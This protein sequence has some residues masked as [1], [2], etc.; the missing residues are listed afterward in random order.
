MRPKTKPKKTPPEPSPVIVVNGWRIYTHPLFINKL[1][2]LVGEVEQLRVA[3]P[4]GYLQKKKTKLLAAIYKM[5]FEVIPENP[6]D[7][8]FLQGNTLGG[9]YRHWRRAKFFEGRY[10]LFFRYSTTARVIVLA[11]VNDDDTL[12]TYGSKT[13]AYA[14]F[15]RMLDKDRPPDDL[16]AL[17]KEAK[18]A[19]A[20]GKKLVAIARGR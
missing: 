14:I 2:A 20:R 10:R 11:W 12:R 16:E 13:D 8:A 17:L 18:A 4:I 3:D 1:E 7:R 6:A 19:V 9:S 15:K 5:A